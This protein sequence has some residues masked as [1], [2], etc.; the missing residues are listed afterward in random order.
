L[1][2]FKWSFALCFRKDEE[3]VESGYQT[4]AGEENKAQRLQSGLQKH[5]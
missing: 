2:N 1:G 5:G 3:D 4:K